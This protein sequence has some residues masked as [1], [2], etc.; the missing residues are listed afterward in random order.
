M[1]LNPRCARPSSDGQV[2]LVTSG[3]ISRI[4]ALDHIPDVTHTRGVYALFEYSMRMMLIMTM[5]GHAVHTKGL[6]NKTPKPSPTIS[7]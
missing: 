2:Q 3:Y 1:H 5:L 7:H 6:A 4:T